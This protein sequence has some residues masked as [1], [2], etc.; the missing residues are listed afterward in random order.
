L[1]GPWID[2]DSSLLSCQVAG[3]LAPRIRL[4]SPPL[5]KDE[6]AGAS[7]PVKEAASMVT[8]SAPAPPVMSIVLTCLASAEAMTVALLLSTISMR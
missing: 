4:S 8:L 6:N 1:T 5:P 7:L 3:L 2:P